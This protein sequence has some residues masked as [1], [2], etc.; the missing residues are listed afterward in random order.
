MYFRS[1]SS[2]RFFKDFLKDVHNPEKALPTRLDPTPADP[3]TKFAI[4]R[5]FG[6][7]GVGVR[8]GGFDG[9]STSETWSDMEDK[10]IDLVLGSD[11][12]LIQS[13]V[14]G[15]PPYII[16]SGFRKATHKNL[17]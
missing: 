11:G 13:K 10:A 4:G 1:G 17:L 16:L 3:S 15:L 9:L 2:G 5:G 7:V 12:D 8:G 6:S 14:N